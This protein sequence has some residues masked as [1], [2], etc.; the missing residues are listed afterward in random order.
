[1]TT[2]EL[3]DVLGKAFADGEVDALTPHIAKNCVYS[4]EYAN[5]R[6]ESADEIIE[7]MK[8]VYSNVDESSKYTYSIVRLDEIS[9]LSDVENL[10]V[11]STDFELVDYGLYLYQYDNHNPVSV[12]IAAKNANVTAM[13]RISAIKSEYHIPS[14]PKIIGSTITAAA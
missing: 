10:I 7:R 6:F 5:K 13:A 2:Y 12:V 9:N 4:S 8:Y 3:M 14:I 11:D 1:M